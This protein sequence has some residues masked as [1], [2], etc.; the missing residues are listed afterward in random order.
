MNVLIDRKTIS[1][2]A[3]YCAGKNF[4]EHAR[5][6]RLLE[7][8]GNDSVDPIATREP[9]IF[10][11]PGTSLETGGIATIPSFGGTPLS[12]N[13]H[14]EVE[15]VLLIG[16]ESDGCTLE[17]APSL[18]RGFG[19][20][21]D[22]TLRDLQIAAKKAGEPWLKCKG[23]RKSALVSDFVPFD[24]SGF[25]ENLEISLQL[26]GA[27]VQRGKIADMLFSPARLVHYLSYI[28]GLRENDLVFTGTPAGVGRVVPGDRLEASLSGV[29]PGREEPEI[30]ARLLAE[31]V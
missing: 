5:E 12:A 24:R 2:G 23:F 29:K 13:M 11:K 22:M 1:P 4:Q 31:V 20:G 17:E 14:H 30:L 3:I 6:L 9:V 27:E 15:L 19:A 25:P 18:I 26:N 10:M 16:K 28:Y 8:W 21:L 7:G